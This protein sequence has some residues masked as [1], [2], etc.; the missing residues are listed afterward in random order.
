MCVCVWCVCFLSNW[1]FP[2]KEYFPLLLPYLFC[3]FSH[4]FLWFLFYSWFSAIT[5]KEEKWNCLK[6]SWTLLLPVLSFN[7]QGERQA[8]CSLLWLGGGGYCQHLPCPEKS[9]AALSQ[10][11]SFVDA[12]NGVWDWDFPGLR[13]CSTCEAW[14]L[15]LQY[16]L[17]YGRS[18][19]LIE[20]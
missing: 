18:D 6:W 3:N 11:L 16:S 5:F 7:F 19:L 9:S 2:V 17:S 13:V 14:V 10:L 4:I 1:I 20:K 15:S 8:L 12:W